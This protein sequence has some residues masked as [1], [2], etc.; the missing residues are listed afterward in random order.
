MFKK[1]K[2]RQQKL[3]NEKGKTQKRENYEKKLKEVIK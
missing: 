2:H 3:K 1:K